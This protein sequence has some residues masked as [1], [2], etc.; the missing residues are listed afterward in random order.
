MTNGKTGRSRVLGV[1]ALMS[2][3]LAACDLDATVER[4][5]RMREA[6]ETSAVGPSTR[7]QVLRAEFDAPRG[8]L[9]ALHVDGIDV[10]HATASRGATS[11]HLPGWNFAREPYACPPDFAVLP[12][13]DV[14]ITSNV[15]PT[16]WRIDS[17]TLD[18]S[19]HELALPEHGGR[20]V[21]FSRLFHS[22]RFDVIVAA[23][24][25]DTSLW[26]IDRTLVRAQPIALSPSPAQT[27]VRSLLPG[28]AD[29]A[30]CLGTEHGESIVTLSADIRSGDA[31]PAKCSRERA[32]R[33]PCDRAAD[34]AIGR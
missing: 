13:G 34:V 5:P 1:L 31:R 33:R 24:A 15:A 11:I 32:Q 20:D 9:W 8:R 2:V 10:H 14:L 7:P 25:L 6:A 19:R 23:G 12:N 17:A 21:G 28:R 26:R 30:L 29:N 27:C 3:S 22:A 16:I 18:V 4:E